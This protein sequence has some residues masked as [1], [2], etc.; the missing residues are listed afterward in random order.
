MGGGCGTLVICRLIW[1]R[2]AMDLLPIPGRVF[3]DTSVVNFVLD[4]GEQ[5][6]EG[7]ALPSMV[8]NRVIQDIVSLHNIFLTGQRACWQLAVSPYTYR[9]VIGTADPARRRYLESWFFEIWHS[10]IQLINKETDLPSFAEA[11]KTRVELLSSGILDILSDIEDRVL[12]CDAI[13][14]RCDGFC[15]RDWKTILKHRGCLSELP[16]TILTPT[17]WWSTIRPYAGLW[18]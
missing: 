13:V 14:Y 11:E 18:V 1:L 4:Y 2:S 10:W 9:E 3:L 12:M 7:A 6:H 17:E 16:I 15:T 5:V 8:N